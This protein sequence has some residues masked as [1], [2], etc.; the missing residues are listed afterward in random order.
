MCGISLL[1]DREGNEAEEGLLRAM[2][3]K[4]LH[5]GPDDDGAYLHKNVGLGHRRLSI[6]EV[7]SK[8][9][10]PMEGNDNYIT[11]NGEIYNYIELRN[12]L[13][14]LGYQFTTASDTEVILAAW[15][16]WG[17]TAFSKMNGMWAIILYDKKLNKVILSRDHFGIKPLF[18][19]ITGQYFLAGS[20]IKQFTVFPSFK[21]GLN[22]SVAYNFLAHGWLNYSDESFFQD[23]YS[24]KPGHYLEYDLTT[25]TYSTIEWYNLSAAIREVKDDF[26]TA[27][28]K[29]LELLTDSIR[30]RMRSDVRV[31]SCLSGG[32]DSSGIVSIIHSNRFANGSFATITSCYDDPDYDERYFRDIVSKHTSYP[33]LSVFPDLD[34]LFEKNHLDLMLY[35]LEQ[36][37][38]TASHYSEFKV[39]EEAAKNGLK[40]MHDG[41]GAD[42]YQLGYDEFYSILVRNQLRSGNIPGYLN[43]VRTKALQTDSSIF[44]ELRSSF[45]NNIFYPSVI[46]YKKL[47]GLS[48]DSWLAENWTKSCRTE[49]FKQADTDCNAFSADQMRFSSLPYQLHSQDRNSMHFSV[50]SRLPFLDPRLVEYVMGLPTNYKVNKGYSKYILREALAQLPEQVRYRKHKMGFPAP[51]KSWIKENATTIRKELENAVN[52]V[53]FFNSTLLLRYERFLKGNL[54]YEPIYIRAISFARFLKIFNFSY[55]N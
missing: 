10:Q 19:T 34:D 8:G 33:S 25:N 41:Q 45:Q 16:A 23:V 27:T 14:S 20:E 51:D 50:E 38:A 5:R 17:P 40:V 18:Y 48:E 26:K 13:E 11:Y 29:V 47:L 32:L 22:E 46:K 52:E 35:H 3:R 42:E 55:N 54:D 36:P 6:I 15:E 39:F 1:I 4:V 37:I 43:S 21:A 9:H 12:E 2:N 28:A 49:M 44:K 24:L 53:P 31:G 7:S 30:I